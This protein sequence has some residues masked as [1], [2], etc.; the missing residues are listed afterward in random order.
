VN[1]QKHVLV[2]KMREEDTGAVLEL[3]A[4]YNMAPRPPSE[5]FPDPERSGIAVENTFVAERGGAVVGVSSYFLRSQELAETA[6]LAV[7]ETCRG[8]NIGYLL[9]VARLEEMRSRGIT[10]VRTETDRKE[11][12]SWYVRKFGYK[13]VGTNPKKHD[14]SLPDV[15]HWT[16]LE[17]NLESWSA[18]EPQTVGG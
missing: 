2:R 15:D 16:V 14:F 13:V 9:Q 5:E 18:G 4:Q 6:S 10:T 17:L 12:V 8:M 3:L 7:D 1:H 11:T